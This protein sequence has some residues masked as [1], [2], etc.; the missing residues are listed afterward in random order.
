M[1]R[2]VQ[3]AFVAF[4]CVAPV[5][6]AQD[7]VRE[8]QSVAI[9]TRNASWA[10]WGPNART[11][12]SWTSHSNRLIPLYSFGMGLESVTGANSV[13]RDENR[14][15]ELYGKQPAE[16]HNPQADYCDQTDVYRLQEMAAKAGKK[17][18]VLFIFDGMDWH[19][20]RAA[21]I[22]K[23]QRLYSEGRGAG[24]HFLD[25]RG[26]NTDFGYF[27][28]APHSAGTK[29]NVNDQKIT[30]QGDIPGGYAVR[31]AG[32]APWSVAVDPSYWIGKGTIKHAYPDSSATA[33]AMT[34]GSKTYNEAINVDPY[35]RP[36]MT[37]AHQLQEQ[38]YAIGVVTSVPIS[39]ATPA[40]AYSRNVSR[41][42]YQDLTRDLLGLPSVYHP[43]KA[44]P[45]VDVLIG[46]G[47]G[48]NNEKDG[49]QGA[50]FVP[51]NR[52]LT[53]ADRKI[54]DAKNGGKY[55]VTTRTAGQPGNEVIAQGAKQ[56]IAEKQRFLGYFGG[57]NGHLPFQ[58]ADGGYDPVRGMKDKDTVDQP[59]IYKPE[60]ITENP[61]LAQMTEAALDVLKSRSDKMW[62]MVEAGDVDWANHQNN[63]DA[64]IGAVLSGDDA[65]KA[66]TDWI[67]KNV[68]WEKAIV[69]LTADHGHYLVLDD[70]TALLKPK[71]EAA[72]ATA[73]K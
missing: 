69:L 8:M 16:T 51:G 72:K 6:L 42:D 62:L 21:A 71:D 55:H 44:L 67:E 4:L 45:G 59:E 30:G 73:A 39:H 28:A 41:D 2:W 32:D 56:A 12:S 27:V 54:C 38:N 60:D 35:G 19:T 20:T 70:P 5:A 25:Y 23:S 10:H 15:Q 66:T 7:Y 11:Y 58:T 31:L 34:T 3:I 22:Y 48:I 37:I 18:I 53:D 57:P 36:L 47:F 61:T 29:F 40:C 64:S 52:Y 43:G 1:R 65:F 50:N 46:A 17:C 14:L 49:D 68:G 33:T 26:A 13:Y 63:L 9:A 24:L